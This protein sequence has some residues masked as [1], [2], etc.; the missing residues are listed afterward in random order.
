VGIDLGT[1][2]SLVALVRNG[3]PEVLNSREGNRLVPSVV[4]F[5]NG[6]PVV[7]FAARHNKVRDASHT[8]F[9]VKRLLGRRFDDLAKSV[10]QLPYEVVPGDGVIRVKVGDQHLTAIEI[11]AMILRELKASAEQA[12]GESV[13]RAVITV[14]AYFNDAQRQATRAA[15]RLAGLE[16]LR[17]VNEPTA[18]SLAYGLDRKKQ[19]LIAVYDLGGGTFDVS[20]LRLEDGIFEVL[21]TNGNTALGGDDLDRIF[22]A[23]AE[24]D[25]REKYG[26]GILSDINLKAALIEQGESVKITLST[27]QWGVFRVQLPNGL[28]YE[29]PWSRGDFEALAV[30]VLEG[31]R[32]P[33]LQ[34]LKDAGLAAS[35]LSDVVLVGGPTRLQIVQRVAES[36]FGRR[37]NT[38]LHPDEVVALGAAIQADILAGNTTDLLLLDVV[39]LSLGI[40]TYGGLMSPLIP[41]NTRI[42]ASARESFTTFM[43]RQTGVDIHVLQGE[44]DRADENRSLAR[45]KLKGIEPLPAG[46]PRIEVNFLIDADGILQVAAKDLRTGTEQAIEVQPSFG[47]SD[48]EVERMLASQAESQESDKAFRKL[49]DARTEAEPVLR[50][51][52]KNMEKARALLDPDEFERIAACVKA[53]KSAMA[54]ENPEAII[55][56]KY[57]LNAAT[58]H[59]AEVVIADSLRQA[60]T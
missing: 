47:L 24:Q 45:F 51:T 21:A 44:R 15:G 36:I 3:V 33:C 13:T 58:V 43:D 34:A 7:G 16:V 8:V 46:M 27:E 17:I 39:P 40:E 31:T 5:A 57:A 53:L 26:D 12:L 18:A 11:S 38:S 52:E 2:N 49:V 6:Q 22:V 54:G 29:R 59:L 30:H 19:G 37:P 56:A 4:S 60:S 50:S 20:I 25:I 1:T 14:P 9:S 10:D 48:A 42:P 55:T 35:D 41:R 28:T 32:K 23:A